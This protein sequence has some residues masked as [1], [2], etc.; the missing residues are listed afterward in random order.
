MI[1]LATGLF[2][3]DSWP[4]RKQSSARRSVVAH[5]YRYRVFAPSDL[6][7]SINVTFAA[8]VFPT[9]RSIKSNEQTI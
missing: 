2:E 1:G 4:P 9:N 3:L 5:R 8:R 6:R 7:A